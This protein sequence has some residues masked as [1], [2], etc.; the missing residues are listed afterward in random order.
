MV[1]VLVL[2]ALLVTIYNYR[3][4]RINRDLQDI[5]HRS[6]HELDNTALLLD[7]M[8]VSPN[9]RVR[10]QLRMQ[11]DSFRSS[12][13]FIR[14]SAYR[15]IFPLVQ[16]LVEKR[17]DFLT[18]LESFFLLLDRDES[19]SA[20]LEQTASMLFVIS[21]EMKTNMSVLHTQIQNRIARDN[22]IFVVSSLVPLLALTI[23]LIGT[24]IWIRRGFLSRILRMDQLAGCIA[25]GDHCG[26]LPVDA[27]D[28][29]SGLARSFNVMNEA[30]HEQMENL[31]AERDKFSTILASIGDA[32]VAVDTENRIM[33]M[34][35]VAERLTGWKFSEAGGH[36]IHEVV[37]LFRAGTREPLK[38]PLQHVLDTGMPFEFPEHTVLIS[39]SGVEY[40]VQDSASLVQSRSGTIAGAVLVF[41]DI[42]EQAQ[43]QEAMAQ[44][45]KMMSVGG[46]AAGIV[47]EIQCPLSD[48]VRN[49]ESIEGRLLG[50]DEG[51]LSAAEKSGTTIESVAD[52]LRESGSH[53]LIAAIRDGAVWIMRILDKMLMFTGMKSNSKELVDIS[54]LLDN[55]VEL[56]RSDYELKN[57]IDFRKIILVRDYEKHMPQ[58]LCDSSGMQ[59]VFL[60]ILRNAFQV[61][62]V[63]Q[64]DPPRLLLRISHDEER[65]SAC[66]EIADNGPGMDEGVRKRVFEP[67]Y[68][69]R[70]HGEG[71]GLG[72]SI[73]Y[74]IV[75][76]THGG[77][78][79]VRSAP[80][81]GTR[82]SIYLPV[83][84]VEQ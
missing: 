55:A 31:A 7:E 46:L 26:V 6:I 39:R 52:Y 81:A 57:T 76:D 51:N 83:E 42:T 18:L 15:D 75:T 80:G 16:P 28:E 54:M 25:H 64:T 71:S 45:E 60:N 43:M 4:F 73:A 27:D 38:N 19:E 5:I 48:L 82:F 21:H 20:V 36:Y 78:I 56:S 59:Q 33:I 14:L 9:E 2:L 23:L 10:M 69:T 13:S 3:A 34:N 30:V 53:G 70:E 72:L 77:S 17:K 32:V 68:T 29:L 37:R 11:E 1:I 41:R 8:L 84:P 58:V 67:F 40:L 24:L 44:N 62:Y 61:M 63:A 50:T 66:I 12:Q 22:L 65:R 35:P 47:Q 74:F 49:I 79:E